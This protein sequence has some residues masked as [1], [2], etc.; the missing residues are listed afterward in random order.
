MPRTIS[1]LLLAVTIAGTLVGCTSGSE[2]SKPTAT[3]T[4]TL[5][6]ELES[7]QYESTSLTSITSDDVEAPADRLD[8]TITMDGA[9]AGEFA[10][11]DGC[12]LQTDSF[13]FENGVLTVTHTMTLLSGCVA[14]AGPAGH[15]FDEL[16]GEP[17]TVTRLGDDMRWTNAV[18]E[19]VF[20]KAA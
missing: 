8:L 6:A 1:L 14:P 9:G 16:L 15:V 4:P 5:V 13:A 17:V 20:I 2:Q 3:P 19:I 10:F 18:G 12:N 7:G 11:D